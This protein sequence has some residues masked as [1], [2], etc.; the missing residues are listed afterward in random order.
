MNVPLIQPRREL[1]VFR[2]AGALALLPE[3]RGERERR[4]LFFDF[5]CVKGWY[6]RLETIKGDEAY[7]RAR[8]ILL[9]LLRVSWL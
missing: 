7:L 8:R 5:F 9:L 1:D 2:F 4:S 3:R 6:Q